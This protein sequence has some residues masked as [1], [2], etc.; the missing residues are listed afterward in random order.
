MNRRILSGSTIKIIAVIS[1]FI[2]HF[3]AILLKNGIVMNA[4]YETF[5]DSQFSFL[6]KVV[7]VCRI[8]GRAAFPLFCFLLV[9]GFVH[10]H[11]LKKYILQ[12]GLF[13]IVSE[14]IYDLAFSGNIFSING[15]NVM[16]TLLLGLLTLT[17]IKKCNDSFLWAVIFT[18]LSGIVSY[19]LKFDGWY[20]GIIMITVFYLLRN[21]EWLKYLVTIAVT[22]LCGLDYSIQAFADP[23]FLTAVSS[24]V[25]MALYSGERGM[26]MK[27][28]FYMFYPGHLLLLYSLTAFIIVPML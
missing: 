7:E 12:L 3:G 10:T 24:I 18:L 26:R 16:F 2:D 1:M 19:I 22:Y 25:I 15:Q 8:L 6:L 11:N 17:L 28:F 13:A 14:P 5:S 20:Y 27:Y 21:K 9:E 4:T 23:Y